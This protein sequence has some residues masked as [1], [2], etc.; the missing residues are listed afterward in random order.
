M[1][2]LFWA[3]C[4]LHLGGALLLATVCKSQFRRI[5]SQFL[6]ICLDFRFLGL[7]CL[8]VNDVF[9]NSSVC[10]KQEGSHLEGKWLPFQQLFHAS[11]RSLFSQM[12][13]HWSFLLVSEGIYTLF[14]CRNN[15]QLR[16]TFSLKWILWRAPIRLMYDWENLE[17]LMGKF[18]LCFQCSSYR[19][20]HF[21]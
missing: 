20:T 14:P 2:G 12:F 8:M 4:S 21:G 10:V 19:P 16:N 6:H 18:A 5:V 13:G 9:H 1:A 7:P 17:A 3:L 15:W 11:T